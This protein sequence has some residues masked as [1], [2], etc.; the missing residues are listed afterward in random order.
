MPLRVQQEAPAPRSPVAAT[1][2]TPVEYIPGRL[3]AAAVAATHTSCSPPAQPPVFSWKPCSL[4]ALSV[5]AR[6]ATTKTARIRA[7]QRSIARW[8]FVARQQSVMLVHCS[9]RGWREP[10]AAGAVEVPAVAHVD[11]QGSAIRQA[12][13]EDGGRLRVVGGVGAG[14]HGGPRQLAPLG[15]RQGVCGR[16]EEHG[17]V[18]PP[19]REVAGH[20]VVV[21]VAGLE[22]GRALALE[23]MPAVSH[24]LGCN[25]TFLRSGSCRGSVDECLAQGSDVIFRSTA[26]GLH[27]NWPASKRSWDSWQAMAWLQSQL[28]TLGAIDTRPVVSV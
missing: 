26:L 6:F 18:G 2:P 27:Q 11:V 20:H 23:G 17:R 9:V 1:P 15:G 7:I 16:V 24:A 10:H 13:R 14:P 21:A 22:D 25:S 19:E 3:P 28:L 8:R 5:A 12:Q 4:S